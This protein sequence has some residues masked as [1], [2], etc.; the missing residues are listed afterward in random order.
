MAGSG[1][2][3]TAARSRMACSCRVSFGC[4]SRLKSTLDVVTERGARMHSMK[5]TKPRR[6]VVFTEPQLS[7]LQT[8]AARL[9]ITVSDLIRRLVDQFRGNKNARRDRNEA[10]N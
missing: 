5:D 9:G 3:Q 10:A 8:E 4:E 2:G 6:S 7:F 1:D